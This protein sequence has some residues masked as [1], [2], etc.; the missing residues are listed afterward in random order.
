MPFFVTFN[1]FNL[2]YGSDVHKR[3]ECYNVDYIDNSED[4]FNM[5]NIQ[6]KTT[7]GN[8]VSNPI[9]EKEIYDIASELT[10]IFVSSQTKQLLWFTMADSPWELL[11][12]EHYAK[13]KRNPY[14]LGG[15]KLEQLIVKAYL[16]LEKY[17]LFLKLFQYINNRRVS[18]IKAQV[19]RKY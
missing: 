10:S 1:I 18:S 6:Y 19:Y 14:Q 4:N 5:I 9:F 12:K 13:V 8:D 11:Y 15:G 16:R 17:P 7:N 3:P 2:N